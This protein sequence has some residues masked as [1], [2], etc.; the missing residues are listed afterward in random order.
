[1]F[2]FG[3]HYNLDRHGDVNF[4]EP[5]I[6]SF[7]LKP[8]IF[9]SL[10]T[11]FSV[12]QGELVKVSF[13]VQPLGSDFQEP[14]RS[15]LIQIPSLELPSRMSNAYNKIPTYQRNQSMTITIHGTFNL[16]DKMKG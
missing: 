2:A 5:D 16:E 14:D 8:W 10:Q 12:V 7:V 3:S 1:M 4:L 13:S 9:C 6:K 15:I 11:T